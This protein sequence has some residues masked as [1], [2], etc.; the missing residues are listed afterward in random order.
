MDRQTEGGRKQMDGRTD[1]GRDSY[2]LEEQPCFQ[3]CWFLLVL[4]EDG[5]S[6]GVRGRLVNQLQ[7]LLVI[8]L[9]VHEHR[10]NRP[11]DLLQQRGECQDQAQ[12]R[13]RSVDGPG[14]PGNQLRPEEQTLDPVLDL[15]LRGPASH[16]LTSHMMGSCGSDVSTTVG[17]TK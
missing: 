6:Q 12:N 4:S 9:W 2:T 17:S 15:D 13:T 5:S 7:N 11:K 14:S 1:G 10:Q 8:L 16:P 3:F